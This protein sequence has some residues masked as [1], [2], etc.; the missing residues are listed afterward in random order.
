MGETTEGEIARRVAAELRRAIPGVR[1]ETRRYIDPGEV[2]TLDID[3]PTG[4]GPG[5]SIA[6]EY[7]DHVFSAGTRYSLENHA[8]SPDERVEWLVT[9]SLRLLRE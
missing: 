2:W 6:I 5:F 4:Q 9:E 7:F 1:I 8:E 3:H